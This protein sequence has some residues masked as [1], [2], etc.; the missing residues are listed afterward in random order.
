MDLLSTY[1]DDS[2]NGPEEQ[3]EVPLDVPPPPPPELAVALSQKFRAVDPAPIVGISHAHEIQP[4]FPDAAQHSIYH[5]APYES[6]FAPILGPSHPYVR[7]GL[8]RAQKNTPTGFVEDFAIH[9][10]SFDE[11]YHTFHNLGYAKNPSSSD[12]APD[13]VIMNPNKSKFDERSGGTVYN[14]TGKVEK[15]RKVGTNDPT[16]EEFTGP[17]APSEDEVAFK[18]QAHELTDEQKAYIEMKKK[19]KEHDRDKAEPTADS[20]TFHGDALTDYQGRS[21]LHPSADVPRQ[22]PEENFIP[23]RCIHT[24]AGHT[25]GISAIRFFPNTGHLLLSGSMDT[26]VKIWDVYGSRKCLRTYM[27]H[28]KAVRDICFSNDGKRFISSSYD[29]YIKLWDTETGQVIATFTNHKIPYCAKLHPDPD[30]QNYI[31]AGCSDK[32]IIQWDMN[33]NTIVQE[34]DQHLGAV[35]TVTFIDENRRFVSSSDDKTLRVWEWG[36]PVVIK[37]ISEPHMHSMPSI[38]VHPNGAWIAAQSLDNQILVYSTRERFKLNKKKRFL[39]HLVAGFACQVGFSPDGRFVVS[40][41]SEGKVW[42]WDWKSQKVYRTLKCHD[43]VSIGVVWH[44]METSKVATA[45]WDGLIK[46][47]D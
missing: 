3:E 1:N 25:K 34:Y 41:D 23:K 29:R 31:L 17:W 32:K 37:Y 10:F 28:T 14:S 4:Y 30:K 7:D 33:S 46:Y 38:E 8:S 16:S 40:G 47:W 24:W 27:G 21:F 22:P 13:S 45:G 15:K 11:Q 20:T 9:D 26:K 12:F 5:N 42:F 36:I 35:N 39:G 2:S 19:E 44:P 43:G 6:L 18:N